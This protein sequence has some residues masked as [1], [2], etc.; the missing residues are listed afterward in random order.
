M[1]MRTHYKSFQFL[2]V[3]LLGFAPSLLPA[4]DGALQTPPTAT[5]S[6]NYKINPGDLV[7]FRVFQE[8]DLDSVVRVAG[9]GTAIFPLIG[10]LKIG[11]ATVAEATRMIV[12]RLRNGFLVNPQVN[13]TVHEYAKRYFTFLGEVGKP[14]AFDM[15]GQEGIPLLQA[16]GMAG[17]YSKIANPS[18]ITVK[19]V[20]EGKETIIKLNAKRMAKG[21]ESA[22]F[23]VRS[24]DVITV[25][26]AMF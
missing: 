10:S 26:E 19:R 12:A 22:A 13:L 18:N 1:N 24:G 7:D 9:D 3:V 23:M 21:E 14:G 25:G 4:Q 11:G 5:V 16:I 20:V 15:T 2:T 8:S 6:S 17:G